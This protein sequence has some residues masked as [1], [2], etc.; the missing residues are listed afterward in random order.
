MMSRQIWGIA[1]VA[2]QHQ[3]LRIHSQV[4]EDLSVGQDIGEVDALPFWNRPGKEVL[5]IARKRGRE[6]IRWKS[7]SIRPQFQRDV[8][9]RRP[10]HL[11]EVRAEQS[12][13]LLDDGG[14]RRKGEFNELRIVRARFCDPGS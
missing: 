9:S 5:H 14:Q 4:V 6:E 10:L 8:V 11:D 13:R 12:R 1:T 7:W 3:R 2:K